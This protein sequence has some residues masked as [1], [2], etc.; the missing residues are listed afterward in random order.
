MYDTLNNRVLIMFT[1]TP[2]SIIT[3]FLLDAKEFDS[4]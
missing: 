2:V 3:I 1:L 4:I